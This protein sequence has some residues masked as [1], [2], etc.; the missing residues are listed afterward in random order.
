MMNNKP[1][2]KNYQNIKADKANN[3]GQIGQAG[4]DLYQT[5][6]NYIIKFF[7]LLSEQA[8]KGS[9]VGA[10]IGLSVMFIS[11]TI[12]YPIIHDYTVSAKWAEFLCAIFVGFYCRL[13]CSNHMSRKWQKNFLASLAFVVTWFVLPSVREIFLPI[14]EASFDRNTSDTI[15]YP[16]SYAII[17]VLAGGVIEIIAEM[18]HKKQSN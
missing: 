17:C 16:I 2:H 13:F 10:F 18:T 14:F 3:N 5:Q 8:L 15:S 6:T 11:P 9:I 7:K 1:P 12:L 4:R